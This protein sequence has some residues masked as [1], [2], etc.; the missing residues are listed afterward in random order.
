[1]ESY[2]SQMA[3]CYLQIALGGCYSRED[4]EREL[5][6]QK[7][8]RNFAMYLTDESAR[9]RRLEEIAMVEQLL[10][11]YRDMTP[12]RAERAFNDASWLGKLKIRYARLRGRK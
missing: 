12:T 1:M 6:N 10:I 9:E 3:Q 7:P 11:G 5:A 8:A 2:W 4:W